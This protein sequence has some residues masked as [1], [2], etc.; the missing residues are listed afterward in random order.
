VFL[1]TTQPWA[2][3]RELH[4]LAR[5]EWTLT[6]AFDAQDAPIV[7]FDELAQMPAD[8]WPALGF[9]LHPS[10]QA[11]ELSTNAPAL[12]KALDEGQPLPQPAISDQPIPWL[13]WRKA[14]TVCFRSLSEPE[15]WALQTIQAGANFTA[16]CEGLCRWYPPEEAAPQAAQLLRRWIDDELITELAAHEEV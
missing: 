5:F 6:L 8:A 7:R 14:L 16:L 13:V 10:L 11:V 1:Q 12:R 3:R 15:H 9:V 2:Q 4:E